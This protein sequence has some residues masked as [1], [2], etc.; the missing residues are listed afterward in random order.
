MIDFDKVPVIKGLKFYKEQNNTIFHMPGHKQS[1]EVIPELKYLQDNMLAFDVT[2]VEGTDNMFMPE[3]M[4]K[5]SLKLLSD[6]MKSKESYFLVNGST[7]GIYSMILGLTFKKSKIIVQR[8]CHKSVHAAIYLGDIEPVY[9]YP[10]VID[11]FSFASCVSLKN[12]KKA[13]EE[14][15]DAEVVMITSPTYYGTIADISSI[16]EFC[17]KK[18]IHLLVDEAHGAHLAFSPLLP[19]TAI[20]LGASASVTSFHKTLP[21]LTQT[22]VLN[23]SDKINKNQ[24]KKIH[25]QMEI[26]QS[27]SPSYIFMASIDLARYIMQEKGVQLIDDLL[28]NIKWFKDSLEQFPFIKILSKK[29]LEGEDFDPTRLVINTPMLAGELS[30]L[31]RKEYNIQIE[32]SDFNNLVL[33]CSVADTKKMYINLSEALKD[34]FA[35]KILDSVKNEINISEYIS[36]GKRMIRHNRQN[37]PSKQ[38]DGCSSFQM[39]RPLIKMS[40]R[41]AEMNEN[42]EISLTSS[43]GRICAETVTPYPPGIPLL[44][45]GEMVTQDIIGYINKLNKKEMRIIKSIS[46]TKDSIAVLKNDKAE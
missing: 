5:E 33:I 2:E 34:I 18:G 46:Q 23:I 7:C 24:I 35:P 8:N 20:E 39:P 6:S 22:A 44:L 1:V 29:D 31:L 45:A 14:N 36:S 41:E 27:S 42:E 12:I 15:P 10:E 13:Y 3:A 19:K 32:M 28:E 26:F 21:S 25:S 11:G 37:K 43:M 16:A 38:N 17:S 4:I 40:Q 30:K 9:V